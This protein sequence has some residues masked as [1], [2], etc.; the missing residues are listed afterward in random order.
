MIV[1]ATLS[2]YEAFQSPDFTEMLHLFWTDS[3]LLVRVGLLPGV[4]DLPGL[5]G[6][7]PQRPPSGTTQ[8][9]LVTLMIVENK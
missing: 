6:G 7:R 1:L 3:D 4:G 8:Y 9:L 2:T 5:L